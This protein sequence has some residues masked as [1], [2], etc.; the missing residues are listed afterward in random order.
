MSYELYI[1]HLAR[2]GTIKNGA[3]IP[4]SATFTITEDKDTPLRFWLNAANDAL[5]VVAEFDIMQ[6]YI[7]N[8]Q[9]GL[10]DETKPDG[11]IKFFDGIVRANPESNGIF[12]RKIDKDGIENVQLFCPQIRHVLTFRHVSYKAGTVNRSQFTSIPAETIAKTLVQYNCTSDATAGNGRLRAGDL[13]TNMQIPITIEVDGGGGNLL[14]RSYAY[15]SVLG[16]LQ[17]INQI[18]GGWF[19]L[20]YNLGSWDFSW[21]DGLLGDD[22]TTGAGRVV[23]SVDNNTLIQPTAT[24]Q[25]ARGTVAIVGGKGTELDR[26]TRV[27]TGSQYTVFNDIETFIGANNLSEQDAL[28]AA[29]EEGLDD[30]RGKSIVDFKVNQTQDIF[31]SPIDIT[32][33]QTYKVGDAITV[34]FGGEFT[35]KISSAS[36][37]WRVP[38]NSDALTIDVDTEDIFIS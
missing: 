12:K 34:D 2:D 19:K 26:N 5:D 30:R 25:P 13:S 38:N 9:I 16:A 35:R 6:V 3:I 28:Q 1:R 36:F 31:Y 14:T 33:K 21:V 18:G 32:G 11:Y 15:Q 20:D 24:N 10:F 29:G 8:L 17:K 4:L 7:R 23:L 22:K 37:G 27:V